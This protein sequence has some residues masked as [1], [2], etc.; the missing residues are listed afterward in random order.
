MNTEDFNSNYSSPLRI[1]TYIQRCGRYILINGL[2][3]RLQWLIGLLVSSK[4]PKASDYIRPN[5]LIKI[6]I[7]AQLSPRSSSFLTTELELLKLESPNQAQLPKLGPRTPVRLQNRMCP[8][9]YILC[10]QLVFTFLVCSN[11]QE[12]ILQHPIVWYTKPKLYA[13]Q[14]ALFFTSERLRFNQMRF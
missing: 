6:N 2:N 13:F 14:R 1:S 8:K 3:S 10:A 11:V 12:P 4:D 5:C 7:L 9:Y